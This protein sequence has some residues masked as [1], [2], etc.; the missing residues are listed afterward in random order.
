MFLF[1]SQ[2]RFLMREVWCGSSRLYEYLT[3]KFFLWLD[4]SFFMVI[5]SYFIVFY[6]WLVLFLCL[7]LFPYLIF[8]NLLW[9]EENSHA[10][11]VLLCHFLR[12]K[13]YIILLLSHSSPQTFQF[14]SLV[15]FWSFLFCANTFLLIKYLC[16]LS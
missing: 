12:N 1:L 13:I 11:E 9:E 7:C 4:L 15:L 3:Q 14:C 2:K 8:Q 6:K 5:S 10:C 16:Q